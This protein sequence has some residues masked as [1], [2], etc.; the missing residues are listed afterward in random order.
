[1]RTVHKLNGMEAFAAPLE[2]EEAL[3]IYLKELSPYG[4]P[5]EGGRITEGMIAVIF[6]ALALTGIEENGIRRP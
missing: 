6:E 3:G 2:L 4:G 5:L 1:M